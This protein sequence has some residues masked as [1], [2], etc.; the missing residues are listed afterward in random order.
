MKSFIVSG[1]AAVLVLVAMYALSFAAAIY[2]ASG[3]VAFILVFVAMSVLTSGGP[4]VTQGAAA[5]AV[6]DARGY[7]NS[8]RISAIE[9]QS[10][11]L[12]Q[13]VS[14]LNA[15]FENVFELIDGHRDGYSRVGLTLA[16]LKP[17][18][19]AA[20]ECVRHKTSARYPEMV[21]ELKGAFSEALD[22]L[23]ENAEGLTEER[24][25]AFKVRCKTVERIA[26]NN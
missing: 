14:E 11:D 10:D 17:L 3:I 20:G 26:A 2:V 6:Q 1:L 23:N 18:A 22:D 19:E 9:A 16:L 13:A 25:R 5:E 4:A 24:V 15:G 8:I 7:L 21:T 12:V